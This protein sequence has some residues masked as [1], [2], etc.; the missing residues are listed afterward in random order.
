MLFLAIFIV[1]VTSFERQKIK[2]SGNEK[3][4]S[5]M[6]LLHKQQLKTLCNDNI[7]TT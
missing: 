5:L 7:C 3:G 4:V 1:S 6:Q 2:T